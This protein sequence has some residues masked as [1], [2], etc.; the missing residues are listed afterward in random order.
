MLRAYADALEAGRL[1]EAHR[2]SDPEAAGDLEQ[3]RAR[4]AEPEVRRARAAELRAAAA[5]L[6]LD[7]GA[8]LVDRD[9]WRVV[10]APLATARD[11]LDRFLTAAEQGDFEGAYRLLAA[12]WRGRYT[13]A[14]LKQDF[15]SEPQAQARLERARVALAGPAGVE[16]GAI[17]FPID[18]ERAVRLVREGDVFRVA[19]LE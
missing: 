18:A 19:A 5:E 13:P 9:G 11:T 14:Q 8:A 7:A 12:D 3:F 1:E 6:R 16:R 17:V 15:Q 2:L 10:D 4:Y